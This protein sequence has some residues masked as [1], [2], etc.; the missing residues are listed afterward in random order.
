MAVERRSSYELAKYISLSAGRFVGSI[1]R[2]FSCKRH[3]DQSRITRGDRV[4]VETHAHDGVP[5][6]VIE[7]PL[8]QDLEA[9][10]RARGVVRGAR[11][12]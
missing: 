3:A 6:D 2:S 10:V 8:H 9:D 5:V 1:S 4:P 12:I 11:T 7:K